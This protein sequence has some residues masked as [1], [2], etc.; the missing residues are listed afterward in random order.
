MAPW[1]RTALLLALASFVETLG[2]GHLGSFTPLYLQQLGVAPDA[3]PTWTGVLSAVSFLLGFPL[4]PMWGVWADR[5]SRKL[6]ILRSTVG[7]GLIFFLFSVAGEPW[8][9]LVARML[10]GFILGNTGV[11][12]AMLADLT[13]RQQL[14]FAI[15]WISAGSTLGM[16][17]GPFVGGWALSHISLSQLYLI[18]GLA[19]WTVVVLLAVLLRERRDRPR[20]EASTLELLRALPGNVRASPAVPPLFLLYFVVFLGGN[21]QMPFVPLLVGA[22]YEGPDLPLAIGGVALAVGVLSAGSGP[23]LGR[24]AGHFGH[25]AVLTVALGIGAVAMVAQGRAPDYSWLLASR[26]AFGL[27]QGGAAPLVVSMIAAAAPEDRRGSVL[28]IILFP[29]YFAWLFGPLLGSALATFGIRAA[30][31]GSAVVMACAAGLNVMLG[32]RTSR[33]RDL[34]AGA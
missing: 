28:N 15:G 9:L 33:E 27:V 14:A 22:V 18:D 17:V 26:A 8:H 23:L 25:R 34:S 30:F 3:V 7:E 6:I 24:L 4:A 2:F 32:T 20:P 31:V 11:M 12:Y 13:P 29:G 5:Y 1:Q 19:C 16:S 10:V 21:M